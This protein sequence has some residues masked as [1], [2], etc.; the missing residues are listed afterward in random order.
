MLIKEAYKL[1]QHEYWAIN[2]NILESTIR[3]YVSIFDYHIL[4]L[5][6]EDYIDSIN[7]DKLQRYYD[8]LSD[9]GYSSKTIRNINQALASLLKWCWKK[10]LLKAPVT[11]K[12]IIILPK[13]RGGNDIKNVISVSEYNKLLNFMTGHYRYT[14]EFLANT[15]IRFEELGLLMENVDFERK[16]IYIRTAIKK[17]L[18]DYDTRETEVILSK[19]LKS[20]AAYRTVPMTP[21]VEKILKSQIA[22]LEE[23]HIQSDCIFCNTNGNPIDSRNL[24]RYFHESLKKA[25]LPKRGLHSLRKLYINKMVRSGMEPKILQR[26]VGHEEYSTTMKY[27]RNVTD[28][29]TL[30][31]ALDIY[32][33]GEK[34]K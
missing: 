12:D 21:N 26:I 31:A 17:V 2:G 27:Y 18:K 24:L 8:N 25:G 5:I 30:N 9:Q 23:N 4:P 33:K 15:G 11:L 1:W 20:A 22:F 28:E 3:G 10:R 34:N 6:G 32:N 19:N 13:K 7:Y 29:D 16:A 14:I